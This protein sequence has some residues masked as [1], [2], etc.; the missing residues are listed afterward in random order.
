MMDKTETAITIF[1]VFAFAYCITDSI[2]SIYFKTLGLND[3]QISLIFSALSFSFIVSSAII[4]GLSEI[5]S[6]RH[7]LLTSIFLSGISYLLIVFGNNYTAFI[8]SQIILGIG[9][10]GITIISISDVEKYVKNMRGYKTGIT[11][12]VQYFGKFIGPLA[13]AF[14][15]LH[16]GKR[17]S[18]LF[19]SFSFLILFVLAML[20]YSDR[21]ISKKKDFIDILLNSKKF[22]RRK[23]FSFVSLIGFLELFMINIRYVFA[24]LLLLSL[25]FS[26]MEI[27]IVVAFFY[28]VSSL[29]APFIGKL[30]DRTNPGSVMII[31][32]LIFSISI[33]MF[34]LSHNFYLFLV[35]AILGSLSIGA[36]D[37]AT[38]ESIFLISRKD[39]EEMY[40]FF[41]AISRIGGLLGFGISGIVA[42]IFGIRTLFLVVGLFS[43]ASLLYFIYRNP[44]VFETKI[45]KPNV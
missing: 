43:M 8:L 45:F 38:S 41:L 34:Y 4:G 18:I 28:V 12:S 1:G 33:S 19:S 24:P 17:V 36:L 39:Q 25:G 15:A 7:I 13:G 32:I 40:G 20:I 2:L 29:E 3:I 30:L 23:E 27:G 16:Y 9:V 35:A 14:I 31:S 11:F 26:L 5:I 10:S 21:T 42:Q 44:D 22:L 6:K 37:V